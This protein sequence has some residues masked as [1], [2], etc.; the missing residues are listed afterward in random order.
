MGRPYVT[1]DRHDAYEALS[2]GEKD[3]VSVHKRLEG[4]GEVRLVSAPKASHTSSDGSAFYNGGCYHWGSLTSPV[5]E[6]SIR[7]DTLVP[8]WN[9]KTPAGTWVELEVRMC[10]GYVWTEWF[11]MGVWVSETESVARHS[12]NG[13]KSGNWQALTDTVESI[14]PVFADAYQYRITLLTEKW[15]LPDSA[16]RLHYRLGLSL[17]RGGPRGAF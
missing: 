15:G 16:R 6:T 8:S 2:T 9:A 12:V 4:A 13:Q 10:S 7:F 11:D 1:F 14:G 17:H 5:Y 3:G